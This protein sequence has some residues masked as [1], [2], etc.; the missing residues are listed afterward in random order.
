MTSTA[1][2]R[3]RFMGL[4]PFQRRS[5]S[6]VVDVAKRERFYLKFGGKSMAARCRGVIITREKIARFKRI[7]A[8]QICI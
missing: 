2:A 7:I 5:E 4:A 8:R 6:G 1:R 3:I